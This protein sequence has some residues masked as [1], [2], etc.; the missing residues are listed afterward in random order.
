MRRPAPSC[1]KSR[2]GE[3]RY[4]GIPDSDFRGALHAQGMPPEAIEELARLYA[5][6][7]EGS[8]AVVSDDVEA[9]LGRPPISFEQFASD[10]ADLLR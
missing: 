5:I 4:S 2:V 8:C 1:R 6:V 7:R 3:I 10:H 9:V